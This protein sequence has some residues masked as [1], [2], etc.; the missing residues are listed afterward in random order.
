MK[1]IAIGALLSAL[2]L[3][4]A[5]LGL[6]AY[7]AHEYQAGVDATTARY[8][9]ALTKQKNEASQKLAAAVADTRA[10]ERTMQE[11]QAAAAAKGEQDAKAKRAVEIALAAE[12]KRNGGRVRDP[13]A[14]TTGRGCGG[15]NASGAVAADPGKGAS[16][17]AA[18]TGLLSLRFSELLAE[19]LSAAET[20][21]EAYALC[22]ADAFTVR[23][24]K[25]E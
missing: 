18:E 4:A 5:L 16:D 13:W 25:P 14:D 11:Q 6:K 1:E 15:G 8:E 21:N 12:R 7:G 24:L 2:V 22:R 17:A 9:A 19:R 10:I 3:G 20:V 23:G